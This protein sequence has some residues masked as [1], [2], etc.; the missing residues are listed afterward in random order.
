MMNEH[1]CQKSGVDFDLNDLYFTASR[2]KIIVDGNATIL[3]SSNSSAAWSPAP[4]DI[5][6]IRNASYISG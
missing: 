5:D 3:Q 4:F 1:G 2:D 6:N